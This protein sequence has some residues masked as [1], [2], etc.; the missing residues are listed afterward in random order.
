MVVR[1]MNMYFLQTVF[2]KYLLWLLG[3]VEHSLRTHGHALGKHSSLKWAIVVRV[4][5][6][7][8]LQTV[9]V[10]VP[11]LFYDVFSYLMR[12]LFNNNSIWNSWELNS[13]LFILLQRWKGVYL[14]MKL[15]LNADVLIVLN[16]FITMYYLFELSNSTFSCL[17]RTFI[18]GCPF[19]FSCLK[20]LFF[21]A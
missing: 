8:L 13:W 6:I 4:M 12:C 17:M 1:V 20:V 2:V 21:V 19:F 18:F 3:C 15:P 7:Y 9:F 14:L 10:L 11:A 16:Y 5:N